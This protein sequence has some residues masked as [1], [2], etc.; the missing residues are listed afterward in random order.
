[1][2]INKYKKV[3]ATIDHT[4]VGTY[5]NVT[6][7]LDGIGG[8]YKDIVWMEREQKVRIYG[9]ITERNGYEHSSV[10]PIYV[11]GSSRLYNGN[12]PNIQEVVVLN[13]N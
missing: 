1:M 8:F 11:C 12:R 4:F 3:M 13:P 10:C 9:V 7:A 2:V 6:A 5:N